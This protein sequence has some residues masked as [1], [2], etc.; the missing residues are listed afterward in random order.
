MRRGQLFQH[1]FAPHGQMDEHQASICGRVRTSHQFIMHQPVN[2]PHGAMVAQLQA[3]GQFTDGN[4]LTSREALDGEQRL[5]LLGREAGSARRLFAE[6][7]E[8]PE[9]VTKRRERFIL[10]FGQAAGG[11][12][13]RAV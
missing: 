6:V 7:E 12:H 4:L 1:F 13:R 5:M 8:L 11:G 3:F 9:G 10:R 2:Q